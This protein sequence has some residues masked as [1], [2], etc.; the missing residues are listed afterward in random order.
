MLVE[1]AKKTDIAQASAAAPRRFARGEK[2]SV[3][4]RLGRSSRYDISASKKASSRLSGDFGEWTPVAALNENK[5]IMPEDDADGGFSRRK[6]INISPLKDVMA[7][8]SAVAGSPSK[9]FP[10]YRG[11]AAAHEATKTCNSEFSFARRVDQTATASANEAR[12]QSMAAVALRRV[13]GL[14]RRAATQLQIEVR[15]QSMMVDSNLCRSTENLVQVRIVSARVVQ[16]AELSFW[17]T[18]GQ[19][20]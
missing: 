19:R 18:S 6:S 16:S 12:P 13:P 10:F 4:V 5:A 1:E 3:S 7:S 9:R 20:I 2:A 14:G 11:G 17:C 15:P 8:S